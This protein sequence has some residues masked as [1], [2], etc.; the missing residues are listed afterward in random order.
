MKSLLR[1]VLLFALIIVGKL[2]KQTVTVR[3]TAKLLYRSNST[4]MPSTSFFTHQESLHVT[5]VSSNQFW[6]TTNKVE[7]R[8]QLD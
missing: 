1:F 8:V 3:D 2:T 7:Q 5:P 6:R 4:L